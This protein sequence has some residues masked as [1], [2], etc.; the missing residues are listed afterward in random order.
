MKVKEL[1]ERLQTL[2]P[3]AEVVTH[4]SNFEQNN[5]LVSVNHVRHYPNANLVMERFRDAFDGESYSKPI[6]EIDG[7]NL[8]IV[9]I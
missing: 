5:A 1:I 8:P 2:N 7:G 4:S 6:Y 9:I 3:E